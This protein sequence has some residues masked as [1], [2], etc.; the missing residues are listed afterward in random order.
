MVTGPQPRRA[1]RGR[2]HRCRIPRFFFFAPLTWVIATVHDANQDLRQAA[3]VGRPRH[4]PWA[5]GSLAESG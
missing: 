2:G 5:V 1:D 3:G 4:G